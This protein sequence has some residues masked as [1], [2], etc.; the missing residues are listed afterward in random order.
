[1]L[2]SLLSSSFSQPQHLQVLTSLP[3]ETASPLDNAVA[4]YLPPILRTEI[5]KSSME[6]ANSVLIDV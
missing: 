5:E 2:F 1:M 3:Q 6:S 4:F